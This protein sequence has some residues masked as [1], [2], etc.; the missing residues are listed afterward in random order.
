M[1]AYLNNRFVQ[2]SDA[3]LHVS[4]LSLQRAYGLFDF[5]RTLKGK[6]LFM[7]Q[8]LQRFYN[9]AA[10]MHLEVPHTKEELT[11]IILQLIKEA[12]LEQAGVRLLLTGGYSAD[13]YHTAAPNLVITCNPVHT[14]THEQFEKGFSVITYEHQRE[15]P[16]IKSINYL[17]AVWLHPLLKEKQAD[18]VLYH[19]NNRITEFPRAN[20][21]VVTKENKLITPAQNMLH[22]ITR[23]FVLQQAASFME[24]EERTVLVEEVYD[25]AE[26]F[27][28]STT[29][30]VMPV[31]KIDDKQIGNGR[32]GSVTRDLYHRFVELEQQFTA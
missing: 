28:T 15:L 20:V 32:P 9:S 14:S 17:M 4:D 30:R 21:F 11:A 12:A 19:H 31:L 13:G 27:L 5:F 2:G 3:V 29:K 6:P 7:E 16:H 1:H 25:A 22:G 8:H 24:V 23:R 26:V 18:D 10:A